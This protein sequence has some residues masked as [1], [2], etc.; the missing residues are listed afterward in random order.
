MFTLP[1]PP[2]CA[3]ENVALAVHPEARAC[4]GACSPPTKEKD[5]KYNLRPCFTPWSIRQKKENSSER[6]NAN[7]SSTV[8]N[9]FSLPQKPLKEC[10][11]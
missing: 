8:R 6:F 1:L 10:E 9:L 2:K 4:Q 5:L 11:F 7:Y 3:G